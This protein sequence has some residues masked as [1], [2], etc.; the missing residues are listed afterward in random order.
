MRKPLQSQTGVG[1]RF[2]MSPYLPSYSPYIY[3]LICVYI[4]VIYFQPTRAEANF[5]FRRHM[6]KRVCKTL[7]YVS[8]SLLA[9]THMRPVAKA[10]SKIMSGL[11]LGLGL[12]PGALLS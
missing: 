7:F 8:M 9:V 11:L 10:V 4:D 6:Q 1:Q 5:Q 2:P 12:T 3:V